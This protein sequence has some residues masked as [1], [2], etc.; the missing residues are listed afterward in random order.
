MEKLTKEELQAKIKE[1][2][3]SEKDTKRDKRNLINA[4]RKSECYTTVL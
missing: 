4:V 3:A 2:E 1:M